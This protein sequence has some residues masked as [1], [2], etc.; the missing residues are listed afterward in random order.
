M[1]LIQDVSVINALKQRYLQTKAN[2]FE[3]ID[4]NIVQLLEQINRFDNIV[5]VWSCGA[6]LNRLNSNPYVILAL[7]DGG[8]KLIYDFYSRLLQHKGNY[9]K[10]FRNYVELVIHQLRFPYDI[11]DILNLSYTESQYLCMIINFRILGANRIKT[12]FDISIEVLDDMYNQL[13]QNKEEYHASC[14]L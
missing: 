2:D 14:A 5:S 13:I 9:R 11:N 4:E 3:G 1:K 8:D 12:I 10:M 6:H 7:G